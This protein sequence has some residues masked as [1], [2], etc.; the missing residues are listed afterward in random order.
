MY[1]IPAGD[2]QKDGL[3]PVSTVAKD[4]D[5][6]SSTSKS[7]LIL[8]RLPSTSASAFIP[9]HPVLTQDND[10]GHLVP[11]PGV[12]TKTFVSTED[13]SVNTQRLVLFYFIN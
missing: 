6:S 1:R 4:T 7:P 2:S 13:L 12:I 11:K 8:D 3:G 9:I 10:D 5:L